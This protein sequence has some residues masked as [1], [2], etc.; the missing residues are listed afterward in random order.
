VPKKWKLKSA[1]KMFF[2][3]GKKWLFYKWFTGRHIWRQV[4]RL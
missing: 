2:R 3:R 1:E 4:C